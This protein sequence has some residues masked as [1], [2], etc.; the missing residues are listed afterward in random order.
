[1]TDVPK[2]VPCVTCKEQRPPI[3]YKGRGPFCNKHY[4]EAK[5]ADQLNPPRQKS[6]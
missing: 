3:Y 1:M 2:L 5:K 6:Y 4:I